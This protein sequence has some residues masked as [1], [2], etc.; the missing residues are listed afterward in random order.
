[1]IGQIIPLCP[2]MKKRSRIKGMVGLEWSSV[3]MEVFS[4]QNARVSH[5]NPV[6]PIKI[7]TAS[8]TVMRHSGDLPVT[9][10]VAEQ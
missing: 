10:G 2:E 7:M 5:L 6:F 1:V 8:S 3:K 9:I 4:T